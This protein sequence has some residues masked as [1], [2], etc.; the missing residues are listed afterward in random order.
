MPTSPGSCGSAASSSTLRFLFFFFFVHGS[1]PVNRNAVSTQQAVFNSHK[2]LPA[3]PN[4]H[5]SGAASRPLALVVASRPLAWLCKTSERKPQTA[6]HNT[7]PRSV[8]DVLSGYWTVKRPNSPAYVRASLVSPP[9]QTPSPHLC[10]TSH[11][12]KLGCQRGGPKTVCCRQKG[13]GLGRMA[14]RMD[15]VGR[16]TQSKR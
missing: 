3:R 4:T 13:L 2:P 6:A 16:T 9:G 7:L 5:L 10:R 15:I 11:V 8:K 12:P 1:P 14:G